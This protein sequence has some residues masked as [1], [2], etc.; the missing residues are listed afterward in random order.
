MCAKSTNLG[1]LRWCSPW[2]SVR[3][4]TPVRV[5]EEQIGAVGI[6]GDG[7]DYKAQG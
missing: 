2:N 7:C 1:V 4:R 6:L 3:R 5:V